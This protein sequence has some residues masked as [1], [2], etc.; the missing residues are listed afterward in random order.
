MEDMRLLSINRSTLL[1]LTSGVLML[2]Q[3]VLNLSVL[4]ISI[5][6]CNF[7]SQYVNIGP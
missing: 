3:P 1:M 4:P 6:L 7:L 5:P 2:K